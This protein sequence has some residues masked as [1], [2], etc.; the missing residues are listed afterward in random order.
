MP[1]RPVRLVRLAVPG[2]ALLALAASACAKSD[3]DTGAAASASAPAV[4]PPGQ[5]A[6]PMIPEAVRI[7]LDRANGAFRAGR[8]DDALQGYREAA[9]AAPD[10][11][12]PWYGVYMVA[13]AT[14]NAAL[15]DSAMAAVRARARDADLS[16]DTLLTRAH[17]GT[18]I[19]GGGGLPGGHPP[20]GSPPMG[21]PPV[22][23][24]PAS[25]GRIAVP[26]SPHQPVTP[27]AGG[28]G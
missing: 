4:P 1:S 7:P 23:A 5:G 15:A 26:A 22:G 24:P 8:Y 21:A 9:A 2:A 16:G 17:D 13:Q 10:E 3:A 11:A 25:G 18:A 6:A 14:K 27:R 19:P 12:A 28:G 20:V